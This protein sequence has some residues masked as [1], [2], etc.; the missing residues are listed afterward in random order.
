MIKIHKPQHGDMVKILPSISKNGNIAW[1]RQFDCVGLK[2]EQKGQIICDNSDKRY[3][4]RI[5]QQLF[6]TTKS[7]PVA[8]KYSFNV[9]INGEISILNVSRTLMQ[10]ITDNP[11]LLN[12]KSNKHLVI[13]IKDVGGYPSFDKSYV[14]D[15]EWTPPV[16]DINSGEEWMMWIKNNQPDY[17]SWIESNN[18]FTKRKILES[19]L[20]S[21]V[22][23][24]LI[25]DDRETKLNQLDI[26][27]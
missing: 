8:T 3:L 24:E 26:E 25:I 11:D 13:Q 23:S 4:K 5:S 15:S 21:D 12:L 1:S 22:I 6:G 14:C 17:D 10:I 16:S 7:L 27:N 2:H 9:L 20:G 18:V 19:F